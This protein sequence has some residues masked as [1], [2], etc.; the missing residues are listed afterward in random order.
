MTEKR[1]IIGIKR[2]FF[3]LAAFLM[4]NAVLNRPVWAHPHVWV[5][6]TSEI[7]YDPN[8]QVEGVRHA[9]SF[10]EAYSAFA[11][12]G[13]DTN[14]DGTTSR[15]ELQE[16]AKINTES[17]VE[18]NYFTVVKAD[19]KMQEF[20]APKDY[21]LEFDGK[22]LTLHFTLPLATAIKAARTLWVEMYDPTYFVSFSFNEKPDPV[23]LAGA[24]AGCSLTVTRPKPPETAS[25]QAMG[26]TFFDTLSA[27][28][29][30]G[31]QFASRVLVACP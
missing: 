23:M 7:A 15:E 9:W 25:L 4:T 3:F 28:S 1:S 17:L 10:D 20:A 16:L 22:N 11:V 27:G 29:D 13:L 21:W 24:P 30:F 2:A 19:G 26:E 18:F 14:Q 31:A 5:T 8:G 6:M 12:Q